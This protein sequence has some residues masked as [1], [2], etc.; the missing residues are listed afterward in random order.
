MNIDAVITKIERTFAQFPHERATMEDM[1][2]VAKVGAHG[3]VEV[4]CSLP[5]CFCSEA[6]IGTL[7][8]CSFSIMKDTCVSRSRVQRALMLASSRKPAP[9]AERRPSSA[10]SRTRA[11]ARAWCSSSA[12]GEQAPTVPVCSTPCVTVSSAA[13]LCV[14]HTAVSFV[15]DGVFQECP[16]RHVQT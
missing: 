7:C 10:P 12:V 6:Q 14:H 16:C 2:R 3:C 13:M 8:E 9:E 1:G 4:G 5:A 11:S 15:P